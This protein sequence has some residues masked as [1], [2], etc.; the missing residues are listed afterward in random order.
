V[1]KRK[2]SIALFE[3]I[4]NRRND[5]NLNVPKWMGGQGSAAAQDP[6]GVPQPAPPPPPAAA[7]QGVVPA[8]P[9]AEP[10][11]APAAPGRQ[12]TLKLTQKH[13]ILGGAGLAVVVVAA[14][15]IGYAIH[16][17]GRTGVPEGAN[18][19]AMKNGVTKN[20][21]VLAGKGAAGTGTKGSTV[22]QGGIPAP[23]AG[24]S[25]VDGKYY[26][27]V[28]QLGGASAKDLAEAER[29]RA[30]CAQHGEQVTVNTFLSGGKKYYIVWSLRPF[31]SG[32]SQEALDFGKQ[33]E[34]LGKMYFAE[35]KTYN[36]LQRN[37][38]KFDPWYRRA[39]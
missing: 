4:T 37:K 7:A 16:G 15:V 19:G 29:I 13:L 12:M 27:I 26:L 22:G 35:Y 24:G 33:I 14:L 9:A 17:S 30:W 11:A 2:D 31:D 39:P 3:V 34:G 21:G 38:G 32:S 23:A 28:Q 18:G 8:A 1:P 5:V 25:R 10:A 20:S 36:F 6:A